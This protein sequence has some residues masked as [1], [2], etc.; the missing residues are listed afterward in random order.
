ML[1]SPFEKGKMA[2]MRSGDTVAAG[3]Y[4]SR[5]F[6]VHFLQQ[7]KTHSVPIEMDPVDE[8]CYLHLQVEDKTE[9]VNSS[10]FGL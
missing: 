3:T 6:F 7:Q 2:E 9:K 10:S 4:S 8:V 1:F 5:P